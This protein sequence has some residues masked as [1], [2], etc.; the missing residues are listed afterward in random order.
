M[1]KIKNTITLGNE[2]GAT[3]SEDRGESVGETGNKDVFI[4]ANK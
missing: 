4:A 3:V 1:N 2:Q